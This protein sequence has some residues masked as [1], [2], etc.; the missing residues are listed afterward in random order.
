MCRARD[1]LEEE[2][3]ARI[4]AE[5]V[6]SK[7]QEQLSEV[8]SAEVTARQAAETRLSSLTQEYESMR[9]K[10]SKL[11]WDAQPTL[12]LPFFFFLSLSFLFFMLRQAAE[13]HLSSLTLKYIQKQGDL[14]SSNVMQSQLIIVL[15]QNHLVMQQSD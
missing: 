9:S 8:Q 4:D 14:A 10:V 12:F 2:R 13:T 7:L 11:Q 6:V 1:Q 5:D 3:M 15:F